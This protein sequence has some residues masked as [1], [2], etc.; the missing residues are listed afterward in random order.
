LCL[1]WLWLLAFFDDLTYDHRI[2]E[3]R[4]DDD[5]IDELSDRRR[6]RR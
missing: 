1:A 4:T 5:R 6:S 2:D 3:G